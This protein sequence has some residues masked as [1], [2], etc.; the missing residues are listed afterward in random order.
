MGA[1]LNDIGEGALSVGGFL[2]D[3]LNVTGIQDGPSGHSQEAVGQHVGGSNSLAPPVAPVAPY[4]PQISSMGLANKF[5]QNGHAGAMPAPPPAH[6][7]YTPGQGTTWQTPQRQGASQ[8]YNWNS[9]APGAAPGN[10]I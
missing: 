9:T 4:H 6:W 1:M 8:N 10:R 3:P 2:L 5:F 7:G